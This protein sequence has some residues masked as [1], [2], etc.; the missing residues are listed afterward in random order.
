MKLIFCWPNPIPHFPL[1]KSG[2]SVDGWWW[3]RNP[4][5]M[6]TVSWWSIMT[7]WRSWSDVWK[8]FNRWRMLPTCTH[9]LW[10][11]WSGGNSSPITSLRSGMFYFCIYFA[12]ESLFICLIQSFRLIK[13][14][15]KIMKISTYR[16]LLWFN[17]SR[18]SDAYM[19]Q[20]NRPLSEPMLVYCQLKP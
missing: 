12:E 7:R 10:L 15:S 4:F 11:R 8:S 6:W 3:W 19:L 20:W 14:R 13:L 2:S 9:R 1:N 18:L 5:V 16:Q 17:S